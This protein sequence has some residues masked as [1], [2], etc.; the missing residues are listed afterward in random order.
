MEDVLVASHHQL[1]GGDFKATAKA[2]I[3]DVES[4]ERKYKYI[5]YHSNIKL[6]HL[7]N[8]TILK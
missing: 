5:S 1:I 3:A 6:Y 4:V 7:I 2:M 8:T